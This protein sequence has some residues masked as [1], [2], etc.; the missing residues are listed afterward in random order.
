[1]S[2]AQQPKVRSELFNKRSSSNDAPTFLDTHN[3]FQYRNWGTGSVMPSMKPSPKV[4]TT[5]IP[6]NA[7]SMYRTDFHDM[8]LPK[9]QIVSFE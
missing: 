5:D 7:S 1:M 2:G 3:N 6:F 4:S 8:V 9:T